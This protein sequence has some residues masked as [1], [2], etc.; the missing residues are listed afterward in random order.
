MKN[1]LHLALTAVLLFFLNACSFN[2]VK[3]WE[4]ANLASAV[5]KR[6]DNAHLQAVKQHAY[7]SKEGTQG[8]FTTGA[9]G[10]GCN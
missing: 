4:K 5:M 1:T 3:P 7:I 6:D 2:E 8:G 10:C 9:G